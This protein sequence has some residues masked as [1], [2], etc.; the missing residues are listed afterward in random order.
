[1]NEYTH[2]VYKILNAGKTKHNRTGIDTLAIPHYHFEFD[3]SEGHFPLLTTRKLFLKPILIELEGF[4]RGITSKRWYEER[5]CKYWSYWCNPQQ[6]PYTKDYPFYEE[7]K[8][9]WQRK[10]P[11]LGPMGYGY[12][13][14]NFNKPHKPIPFIWTDKDKIIIVN[15]F[16]TDKLVG[17]EFDGKYG[18][19]TVIDSHKDK[20]KNTRFS[21]KFND[22]GYITNRVNRQQVLSKNIFD[23]YHPNIGG[24]A[25]V[26]EYDWIPIDKEK[27]N[28]LMNQWRQMIHRCYDEK[29][30]AYSLYGGNNVYVCN[31][32][33]V[34]EY[35]LLD[36]QEIEGWE[37]KLQNWRSYQLDKDILGY[38]HYSKET[39]LWVTISDNT[40]CTSQNYRF[41]CI[42]PAGIEYKN[43]VGLS[44]FCRK[45]NLKVK[46][47]EAS[48]REGCNTHRGWKFTRKQNLKQQTKENYV[49]Q[50]K[51]ILTTL[52]NNPNDR[53]MVCSAWN[54]N[55]THMMALPACITQWDVC[56]IDGS[57]NLSWSQRSTDTVLGL[58][59]DLA[60]M[61][62][63][64]LLLCKHSGLKPGM[65]SGFLNDVHIY[66][67]HLDG[68]K[69]QLS[70]ERRTLPHLEITKD[71]P[72]ADVGE[73]VHWTYEDVLLT[74]YNP[75]S[76]IEFPIAV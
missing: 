42:S 27:K 30:H 71:K 52:K 65:L 48:I 50:L 74:D 36:I 17:Q 41:D 32:W 20:Y 9:E 31:R 7:L 75:H 43:V 11:D 53:R 34:F 60:S 4:L 21:V 35:F 54:P 29:N 55:Q 66:V 13:W 57:L 24:V 44:R 33:L 76:K 40:N 23:P 3:M 38:N 69:E 58:P 37:N 51:T 25:A 26:G 70:R 39:C 16:A 1:M 62:V 6:C 45:Y 63:L 10:N 49:D 5:G 18:K 61:A 28:K 56:V 59:S 64:M 67:N 14:R 22:T 2:L 73:L 46:N 47:V 12:N 68:V 72:F 8:K 19:Y 15:Q